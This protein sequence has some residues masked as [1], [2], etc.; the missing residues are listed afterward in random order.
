MRQAKRRNIRSGLGRICVQHRGGR[1]LI[2][3]R[4]HERLGLDQSQFG[5]LISAVLVFVLELVFTIQLAAV[6]A[7]EIRQRT[8][9]IGVFCSHFAVVAT[10][11]LLQRIIRLVHVAFTTVATNRVAML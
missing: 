2:R 1:G 6:V 3:G 10:V 9:T 7:V 11:D 8:S 5:R 4:A